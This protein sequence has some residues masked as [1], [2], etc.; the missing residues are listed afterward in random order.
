MTR[1]PLLAAAVL[2]SGCLG[3]VA[4]DPSGSP[5]ELRAGAYD[6][7]PG[8]QA[9]I[10]KVE[11][12]GLSQFVGRFDGVRAA[13][14]FDAD[15]PTTARLEAIVDLASLAIPDADF[16]DT[17]TGPNWLNAGAHPQAVFR[18]TAVRATGERT[19]VVDGELTFNGVTNPVSMDVVFNGGARPFPGGPYTLGFAAR[20]SFLRSD[21]GID[22]FT[23]FVGDE[24]EFEIH[25]EFARSGGDD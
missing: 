21:F 12:L 1:A 4:P 24:V 3:L 6:L 10:F 9:L 18:S 16:A 15:D 25:A 5:E 13:L 2:L 7:D 11:H 19:G 8:H 23:A 22:R 14:D 17:L 20:G